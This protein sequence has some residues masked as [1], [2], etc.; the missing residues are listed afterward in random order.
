MKPQSQ[1]GRRR[2]QRGIA[3]ATVIF[4]MLILAMLAGAILYAAQLDTLGSYNYAA[5]TRA[6]YIAD[7]GLQQAVNWFDFDYCDSGCMG[8]EQPSS[9]YNV[10]Q[11]P[12]TL[13][14][15]T[16]AV[17]LS[18]GTDSEF[19]DAGTVTAF[20][21]ALQGASVGGQ[22]T[23]SI[24]A[25]LISDTP[26][27]TVNGNANQERWEVQV[28][29]Y[30]AENGVTLATSQLTGFIEQGVTPISNY[31]MFS[32]G[33]TCGSITM[34]G[35]SYTDSYD[36]SLG[37]D[38]SVNSKI[39]GDVGSFGNIQATGAATIGGNAYVPDGVYGSCS[40]GNPIGFTQKGGNV[41]VT[42]SILSM[43]SQCY[44]CFPAPQMVSNC[45]TNL[46]CLPLPSPDTSGN[47]T[48]S[49]TCTQNSDGSTTCG[50]ASIGYGNLSPAGGTLVLPAGS[51]TTANVY[52][53]NT[54]TA[55]ANT[56]LE[57]SGNGPVIVNLVGA[58]TLQDLPNCTSCVFE[59]SGGAMLNPSLIPA[60]FQINYA[61]T[62]TLLLDT[63]SSSSAMVVYAPQSAISLSG[64][65]GL[66]GSVIGAS[67]T[68]MGSAAVHYDRRLKNTTLVLNPFQLVSWNRQVQ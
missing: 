15:T 36:S 14:G 42:G 23:F 48:L 32:T 10:T 2:R 28:T 9:K 13:V 61:G 44:T 52:Y 8:V 18:T 27:H 16:T 21:T 5:A 56:N 31:A 11:S 6:G 30:W 62:G 25:T 63:G 55:T 3:L 20:Q 51:G 35:N 67:I 41:N 58:G 54:I 47:Y 33:R 50:A 65:A 59:L 57:I 64:D 12:V 1:F 60:D 29:G 49:P 19:P 22:G 43:Q 7:A 45:M 24:R 38:A 46:D 68:Q 53:I 26:V 39:G 66:Y 4:L 37:Y 17:V 40:A 34:Q